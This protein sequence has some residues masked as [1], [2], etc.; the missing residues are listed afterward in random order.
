M[1]RDPNVTTIETYVD[2]KILAYPES[3]G[4]VIS[5][6]LA[7]SQGDL[8]SG[9]VLGK[10][11]GTGKYEKYTAGVKASLT[12]N[13]TGDNNDLVWTWKAPGTQGNNIKVKYTDPGGN[14]KP[15]E[16]KF[17]N[18]LIDISLATDGAGAI[19]TT[20]A[21]ITAAVAA[22]EILKDKVTTANATGND[23]TGVVTAI[24]ATA[25]T[26]GTNANVTPAVILA[27]EVPDSATDLNVAVYL[28]GVFYTAKLTG[29]DDVAKAAMFAREVA[30][31]TIVPV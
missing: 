2:R 3:A 25:L 12:T 21:Q 31:V 18:N 1:A 13:L 17:S 8:Q 27:E 24:S 4:P 16:V 22:D 19:T 9:R 26:G 28:G 23:G 14:S 11:T 5:A 6:L 29:M 15:L 7:A 20:A 30:D 10:N